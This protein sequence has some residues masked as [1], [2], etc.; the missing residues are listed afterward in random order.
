METSEIIFYIFSEVFLILSLF[1]RLFYKPFNTN[2]AN[3]ISHLSKTVIDERETETIKRFRDKLV[4]V[5]S[6]VDGLD[7]ISREKYFKLLNY[8]QD[9]LNNPIDRRTGIVKSN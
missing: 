2:L 6:H 7:P 3:F 5:R 9:V 4:A 8:F 1:I